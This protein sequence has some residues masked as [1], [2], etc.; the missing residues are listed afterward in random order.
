MSKRSKPVRPL[1]KAN[2]EAL[3]EF[4]YALRT[5]LAF[6]ATAAGKAG[7]RPQ[8]HQALLAIK[9][10]HDRNSL[11]IREIAAR[12][13]IRHHSA[14]ELIN[15]LERLGLVRRKADSIDGRRVQVLLTP[16][17]ETL[18]RTLS[19]AHLKELRGVRPALA[20]LLD[21]LD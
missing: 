11:S 18:L 20:A 14:V 7:L 3:A 16:K 4:R 21:E 5:F 19:I 1:T 15:R 17:A 2:Y 9:G 13:L 12:L 10:A 6:S 8:Q